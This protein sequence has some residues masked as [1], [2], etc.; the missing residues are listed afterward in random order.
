LSGS[1][2][3]FAA[4]QA[5]TQ[6]SEDSVAFFQIAGRIEVAWPRARSTWAIS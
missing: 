6:D 3:C 2:A 1:G 5:H 4:A